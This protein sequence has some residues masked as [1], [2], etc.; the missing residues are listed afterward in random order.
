LLVVGGFEEGV[1]AGEAAEGG[2]VLSG[3]ELGEA[4]VGVVGGVVEAAVVEEEKI[5]VWKDEQWPVI[6]RRRRTW[7]PGSASRTKPARG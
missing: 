7:A 4:G 1:E 3:A 2:V 6:K 5:A